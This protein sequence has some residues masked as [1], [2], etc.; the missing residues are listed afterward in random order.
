M[1][2]LNSL[3]PIFKAKSVA[4]IGA[5]TAPGKLGHDILANLK[6]GGF[7]GPI[8]PVNPKAEEILGLKVYKSITETPKPPDLA[9]VVIPARLVAGTL[10]QA[11]DHGVKAAVVITGGFAEAGADG[12]RLQDELARVARQTGIRV[13]GPNCQGVNLPHHQMCA[14]WP[15][16]TTKG[17][18]AFASQSGTVGA[19]FLDLAAAEKL[20]VSAFISLGN[21]VDVDEAEIISYFNTDPHTQVIALY[22]EGVKRPTYFL[23]ALHEAEKPVVILKAGRTRRGS[24]AAESHTKSLAGTDAVYDALFEKYKVYRADTFEELFDFAKALA[25]LPE[26]KGPRLMITT[27]S[28]G[29]AI[30][31]IDEAEKCGLL[32]PDPSPGLAKNL[33]QMVPAHCPVGNPVDLTG[34]VMADAS[35]YKKVIDATRSEF[36]TQVVIFGDPIP[37]SCEQV[38]P[39]A[40]ELVIFMGGAE[41]ERE[42]REKFYDAGIPV[43]PT[44]ERGIKALSQ[45]FRFKASGAAAA[46]APVGIPGAPPLAPGLE[47]IPAFE[48]AV[49]M[50]KAGI[51]TASAPL[52][53]T[54]DEAVTLAESFG[55]PVALKVASPDFPHKTDVGGVYLNLQDEAMVRAAYQAIKDSARFYNREAALEGVTVSPMAKPGALEVILGIIT[56]PQYGPVLMFGLGGVQTEIYQDVAF[57]LLPAEDEELVALMKKVKGYPLLAGFRGRPRLDT[58][59]LLE[60]M[61]ALARYAFKHPELDQIELNPLLLYPQGLFAV[62]VRIFSRV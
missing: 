8:Y 59:A 4:V 37:G 12:E 35:L 9:V 26:P 5:S 28:G 3:E 43:F 39:G 19:A 57:C 33:R 18:I 56:D 21:R 50:S 25:Y 10:E 36:D 6:N 48:A 30:L 32:T 44:P 53:V 58:E 11:A 16:I 34:D 52:A 60:A 62:D 31:A 2:S 1:E 46:Q 38:T 7:A 29:A 47:L 51:P 41:V 49:M 22:L 17:K 54:A 27:S 20:G 15:L 13:I 24:Q 61:K 55:Y 42:E 23:D 45:F 40:S 14:S